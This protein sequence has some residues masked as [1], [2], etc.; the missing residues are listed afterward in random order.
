M[1][2]AVLWSQPLES[3]PAPVA[4]PG[5]VSR[6]VELVRRIP[7]RDT[8]AP[9]GS[10]FVESVRRLDPV[11]RERA[12]LQEIL[13]GN[14]PNFL[15]QLVP[16]TLTYA[17]RGRMLSAT[18]FVMP[19]YL[20]IGADDDFLRI[21]MNLETATTIAAQFGFVLPTRRVVD[22]INAQAEHHLQ[23]Q[24]LP[25]GPQMTSTEYYQRHNELI[26]AQARTLGVT[27]GTLVAGH[28]KDVVISNLLARTPGRIAI[29]G[30]HR[31]GGAPIQPLSTV[32]GACYED[33]SH[34]IR[35]MSDMAWQEGT[36]R[37]IR[38][39]LQDPAAVAVLSDEG[40]MAA[41]LTTFTQGFCSSETRGDN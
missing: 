16:V 19:D 26:E 18:V 11:R 5:M 33:Y 24:P 8:Q 34:G 37:P 3:S 40:L 15:R 12:V 35:L 36:F 7:V 31:P 2:L 29:Y 20:A 32:H 38:E 14:V 27:R 21:P 17:Q 9:V 10:A 28:K 30:W 22:A 4:I 39:I 1:S 13:H 6:T 41:T 23:P 25:P